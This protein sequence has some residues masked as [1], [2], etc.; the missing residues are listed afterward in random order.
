MRAGVFGKD[1]M[2]RIA[3]QTMRK[4]CI[5]RRKAQRETA[6]AP[7][8]AP[9]P[10]ARL[11]ASSIGKTALPLPSMPVTMRRS[12]AMSMPLTFDSCY[13]FTLC[14]IIESSEARVKREL[15]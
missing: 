8:A 5:G 14:S 12:A 13:L 1:L 11:P 6:R 9:F 2:Q 10:A 15:L 4:G 3:R 7:E